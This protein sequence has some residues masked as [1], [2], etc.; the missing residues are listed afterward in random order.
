MVYHITWQ[1]VAAPRDEHTICSRVYQRSVEEG[2]R[3]A[4]HAKQREKHAC[5]AEHARRGRLPLA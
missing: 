2:G 3:G 5:N 4:Q 1:H